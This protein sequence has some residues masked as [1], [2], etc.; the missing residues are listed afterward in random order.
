VGQHVRGVHQ[1]HDRVQPQPGADLVIDEERLGHRRRVCQ[2]G[3][4]HD[5][6]VEGVAAAH[7]CAEDA[8]EIAAN[9]AADASV[10]HLEDLFLRV[11]YERV[12][13]AH[14]AELV[15]DDRD[16]AAVLLGQDPVEQCGLARAQE[17]G[18][19]G[20]RHPGVMICGGHRSPRS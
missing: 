11:Q 5:D 12:V 8:D 13:H 17:S 19:Y 14:L 16:P 1:S 20:D 9:G 4:L 6:P 2:A 3:G 15:L 10:V 18:Q 7:E